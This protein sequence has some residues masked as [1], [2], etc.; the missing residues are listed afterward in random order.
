LEIVYLRFGK[1]PS[2]RELFGGLTAGV[3]D[4]EG[5]M[6]EGR[7]NAW[8]R[9]ACQTLVV[10]G[11]ALPYRE[12]AAQLHWDASA[13]VGG[14]KRF[15]AD[16]PS[17]GQDAGFGPMGQLAAHVALLPLVHVGGYFGHDISPLPIG[18][19]TARDLTFG[20]V[21]AKGML[22]FVR[23][24]VRAWVFAGF[25]YAGVYQRS[26]GS[27]FEKPNP[28]GGTEARS[29][30]VEGAGGG[31]FEVPFGI[32]ASYKLY[33]PW[34]ICA[35]LGG[36][37][38]FGQTGSVYGPPGPQ[39]TLP[40]EAGQNALPAGLDRLAVGLTVGVLVVL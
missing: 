19:G 7:T 39:L 20:G 25:G 15:L 11:L 30:R 35:E 22:P 26:Y 14:M 34:E 13:Q 9:L 31:F 28:L 29:G 5:V 38:G 33:K 40:N 4:Y 17:G 21:R 23:G 10:L 18:D 8:G 16:R 1:N 36:R 12:A 37:V 6:A 32:G 24:A 3:L 2:V 27:T